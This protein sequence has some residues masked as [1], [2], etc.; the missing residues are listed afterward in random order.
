M[1]YITEKPTT[2]ALNYLY[3]AQLVQYDSV[4]TVNFRYLFKLQNLQN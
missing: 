2:N 3:A 1:Q 4:V